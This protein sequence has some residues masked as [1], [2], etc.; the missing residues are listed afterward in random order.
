MKFVK[1]E[2]LSNDFIV[3]HTLTEEEFNS[4]VKKAS[5]LCDRRRGIGADGVIFIFNRN[6]SRYYKN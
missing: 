3:T 5:H 4:A 2:G 1:M 6:I